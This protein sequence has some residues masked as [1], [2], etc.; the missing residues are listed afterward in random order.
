M[1]TVFALVAT[2]TGEDSFESELWDDSDVA[3]QTD[4]HS[5]LPISYLDPNKDLPQNFSWGD[6]HGRSYLTHSLNQHIPHYCG[7]CW[8]HAALSSLADRIKI[9]RNGAGPDINLSIQFILNCGSEAGSCHGGSMLKTFK[10]IKNIGFVPFETCMPYLACSS[11]STWGFCPFVDT[12]CSPINT[13]RT[14]MHGEDECVAL[15][16]FPNATVAEYGVIENDVEAVKAEIFARGPVTAGLWGK[17][18]SNFRGGSIFDDVDAPR[19]STHAVSIVGWGLDEST[20][21]RYW[22]VRNSWGTFS[23]LFLCSFCCLFFSS[24]RALFY[25]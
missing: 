12:T 8:A 1:L 2:T 19:N 3:K 6:V 24:Q 18:L 21:Q 25:R 15:D 16:V 10:F 13:C 14:C 17:S 5:P 22:I 11:E 20:D 9:D 4:Y 7:S 23:F